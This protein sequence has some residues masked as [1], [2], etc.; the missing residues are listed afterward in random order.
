MFFQMEQLQYKKSI[1][2]LFEKKSLIK[3]K[4]SDEQ[5]GQQ[6]VAKA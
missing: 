3:A 1:L 2:N 4:V 6:N 5:D